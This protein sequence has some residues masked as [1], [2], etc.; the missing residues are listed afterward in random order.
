MYQRNYP[1]KRIISKVTVAVKKLSMGFSTAIVILTRRKKSATDFVVK[2]FNRKQYSY[3]FIKDLLL[4]RESSEVF[5]L[6]LYILIFDN[7]KILKIKVQSLYYLAVNNQ[8]FKNDFIGISIEK[9]NRFSKVVAR[10][11]DIG[12]LLRITKKPLLHETGA[13][14][15]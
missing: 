6:Y 10:K 9:R 7:K 3:C 2:L 12:Y 13:L 1:T 15:K 11:L 14:C 8:P 5:S 4:I